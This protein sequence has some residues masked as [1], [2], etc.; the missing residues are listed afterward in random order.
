MSFRKLFLIFGITFAL[1][2]ILASL[3]SRAHADSLVCS[4]EGHYVIYVETLESDE[5]VNLFNG[6]LSPAI[7]VRTVREIGVDNNIF[8][9]GL[10]SG[11]IFIVNPKTTP[12][13][14]VVEDI[15]STAGLDILL[16]DIFGF[17]SR[18]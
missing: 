10:H 2:F 1:A 9:V 17:I 6:R 3:L 7:Q 15:G 5:V 16:E 13:V 11:P 8:N 14:A 18:R 4:Y 12:C